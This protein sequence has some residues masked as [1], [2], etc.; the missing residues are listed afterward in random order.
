MKIPEREY[1]TFLSYA[2]I[3]RQQAKTCEYFA[4]QLDK[5]GIDSNWLKTAKNTQNF[6]AEYLEK[7]FS[8]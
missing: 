7:R 8:R 3:L 6:E 2:Y 4:E 5:Y 1:D